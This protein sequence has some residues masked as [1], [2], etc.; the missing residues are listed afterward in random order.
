MPPVDGCNKQDYTVL[1]VIG[2]G[3]K[4]L[5]GSLGVSVGLEGGA[6]GTADGVSVTTDGRVQTA[7]VDS[8]AVFAQSIGGGGG[9]GGMSL[10]PVLGGSTIGA[11]IGGAGGTGGASGE[12]TIDNLGEILTLGDNSNGLFAQSVGGGGGNGGIAATGGIQT[13]PIGGTLTMGGTGGVVTMQPSGKTVFVATTA[14]L[15][16]GVMSSTAPARIAVYSDE[17]VR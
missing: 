5:N 13:G 8:H 9:I 10:L 7:G 11:S 3:V 1:I 16:R 2:V 14:N 6:G 17:R 12:V 4:R 15:K